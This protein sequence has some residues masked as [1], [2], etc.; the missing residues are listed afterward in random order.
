MPTDNVR[1][2][3]PRKTRRTW[4][5][6][7]GPRYTEPLQIWLEKDQMDKLVAK[8]RTQRSSMVEVIRLALSQYL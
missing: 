3:K 5:L 2:I 4:K 8:A 6:E 7:T 1:P